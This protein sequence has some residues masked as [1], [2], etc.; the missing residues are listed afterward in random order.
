MS[1]MR[2]RHLDVVTGSE[3]FRVV[4]LL[5]F[6]TLLF[7]IGLLLYAT[8]LTLSPSGRVAVA[9]LIILL[10]ASIVRCLW[11]RRVA[12][13]EKT[14]L[15]EMIV[16]TICI[17]T[18]S[19][20]KSM[21]NLPIPWLIAVAGVY[22]LMLRRLTAAAMIVIVA[23][24]GYALNMQLQVRVGGWLPDLFATLCIGGLS[25]FLARVLKVN[26]AAIKRARNNERRFNAIARVT[27][28]VFIITDSDYRMKYAN[29]ALQEVIGYS[30]EEVVENE[31]KPILHPDD[32][33]EHKRKLRYLRDT[34]HSTIFSRHRTRHK[35]GQ[36]VWLETHGYNMLHDSAINGLV[37][38]LEDITLRKD[39]ELK[40]QE[41]TALLR[42]V[43]D[44]NPSMIYAKDTEGRYTISNLS[45]QKLFGY[46]SEDELRGKNIH[47]LLARRAQEGDQRS[48]DA[49]AEEI[50]AQDRHIIDTGMPLQNL[51]LKGFWRN[52]LDRW[53]RTDKYP[54]RDTQG[55]ITG[56]LG[57]TRDVTERKHYET[58]IEHQTM[59]DSLTGLPNRRFLVKKMATAMEENRQRQGSLTLLFCDLD[60]FKSVND[61]HGHDFGDKCLVETARRIV[62]ILP[63]EDFVAR[64]GGNEFVVLTN[65]SL[66][67][68]TM[69]ADA[70]MRAVS[71]R[72]VFNDVVIKLQTSIG[73]AQLNAEHRTP[74]ELIQDADAAMYQAKERGRNRAAIYDA[75]LQSKS[76]RQARMD[77]ALRF[78]LERNEFSVAYQPKITLADG[79]LKGFELLL[80]WNSPEYGLVSPSEFIPIA[81]TSGLVVPIGMWAME[82]ACRQ[83]AQW[84]STYSGI[85]HIS[86]A[87]NVSMRQLLQTSFLTEVRRILHSTG[88]IPQT[89][90]LELTETSA[91]ANPLQTI[92]NLTMLKKLGLCLALDDFGTGYSSLAYLQKLPI[93]ILKIDKTFVHGLNTDQN[94]MQIIRLIMALAQALNLETI[95]EGVET[96]AHI[97]ELRNMGCHIGQGYFFSVPLTAEEAGRLVASPRKFEL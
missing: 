10:L 92:E 3:I 64:F 2:F 51:E 15:G 59:H 73:I 14:V 88:V 91:M 47:E 69:K 79:T 42:S 11:P 4:S 67:E 45:F 43:L 24:I 35:N 25:I 38:S 75:A 82:Q 5:L 61:T 93:D 86:V 78:A 32:E 27:R 39:A 62:G 18:L 30:Y 94:D 20:H 7:H 74:A 54:L 56:V 44:L 41:E 71:E 21:P 19:L 68:A 33:K 77:V 97:E 72:L 76:S 87:V 84:Q 37:F 6:G 60:F 50:D 1:L 17:I 96:H 28:H 9:A 26:R 8:D 52:D 66:A 29:P 49:V 23:M 16:T 40:L 83:L 57:I 70:I 95:A 63:P 53:Y 12:L 31:I 36:W 90:E 13:G 89:L 22:P 34:P 58:R 65:A 46:S 85:G 55:H 48:A 81:E 80:R